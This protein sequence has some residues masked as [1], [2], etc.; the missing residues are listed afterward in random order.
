MPSHPATTAAPAPAA[1]DLLDSVLRSL[2]LVDA[3]LGTFDL[4]RPWGFDVPLL[5][6]NHFFVFAMREGHCGLAVQGHPPVWLGPGDMALVLGASHAFYSA[7]EQPRVALPAF[8]AERGL[9]L[10]GEAGPRQ[11][12]VRLRWQTEQPEVDRFVSLGLIVRDAPRHPVL[13]MLPRL[14]VLRHDAEGDWAPWLQQVLAFVDRAQQDTP[15][16]DSVARQL[17][18]LVFLSLV[19]AHARQAGVDQAGWLRGLA[20]RHI[21]AALVAMHSRLAEPWTVSRLAQVS[22]LSRSGFSLRFAD[23]V[24]ETPMAHLGALRMQAA[25]EHLSAGAAVGAVVQR[26]GYQ[27]EWA[28]RRAFQQRFGCTPLRYRQTQGRLA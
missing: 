25:A 17:A 19:R 5:S 9:P 14:M 13:R 2:K 15:G 6:A 20:D 3:V 21:G 4:G 8:W 27:S 23:L 16:Y 10:L 18:Y 11:A 12:P 22:G 28:F 24:G 7:P 1:A 26:V